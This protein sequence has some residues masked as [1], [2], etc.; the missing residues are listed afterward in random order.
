MPAK[1]VKNRELKS[2][3]YELFI[4]ALSILSIFNLILELIYKDPNLDQVL[5]IVTVITTPI[6]LGIFLSPIYDGVKVEVLLP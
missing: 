1:L 6:F 3:G 5:S 2:I 4:G